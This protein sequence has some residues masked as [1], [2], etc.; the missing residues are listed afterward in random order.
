[1][2][3]VGPRGGGVLFE[4]V[5]IEGRC[6]LGRG[7]TISMSCQ[8]QKFRHNLETFFIAQ[9]TNIAFAKLML[10]YVQNG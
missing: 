3:K 10:V 4:R 5:L 2:A 1:M 6:Y 8:F 9:F 7:I